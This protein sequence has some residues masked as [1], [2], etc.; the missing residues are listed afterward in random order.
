MITADRA[1][2]LAQASISEERK[3]AILSLLD[4]EIVGCAN[5]GGTMLTL[6]S[7]MFSDAEKNFIRQK[8]SEAGFSLS[9]VGLTIY[10]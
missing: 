9:D 2:E 3:A 10:W 6:R 7:E 5:G 8:M 1:R 4:M